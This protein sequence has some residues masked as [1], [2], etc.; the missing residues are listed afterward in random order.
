VA[1]QQGRAKKAAAGAS[2]SSEG[3]ARQSPGPAGGRQ[4]RQQGQQEGQQRTKQR[5]AV[6]NAGGGIRWVHRG[7]AGRGGTRGRG[8]VGEA[9]GGDGCT[10]LPPPRK[11]AQICAA[12]SLA[13]CRSERRPGEE[14]RQRPA[15]S[16]CSCSALRT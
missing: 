16:S 13:R 7:E 9:G 5:G 10:V 6:A 8:W 15:S 14:R 4:P 1:E 3:G 11:T 2:S 12:P